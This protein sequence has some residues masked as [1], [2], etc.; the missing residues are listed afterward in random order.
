ME[1][2]HPLVRVYLDELETVQ[3]NKLEPGSVKKTVDNIVMHCSVQINILFAFMLKYGELPLSQSEHSM[4]QLQKLLGDPFPLTCAEMRGVL[5]DICS[6]RCEEV[7][8]FVMNKIMKKVNTELS[9]N[10]GSCGGSALLL[11]RR[12]AFKQN[13]IICMMVKGFQEI[14]GHTP[15]DENPNLEAELHEAS[16]YKIVID[17]IKKILEDLTDDF[18]VI[19]DN[20]DVMEAHEKL[21][22]VILGDTDKTAF[23][24][25]KLIKREAQYLWKRVGSKTTAFFFRRFAKVS[26]LSLVAKLKRK[27]QIKLKTEE[28]SSA[29]KILDWVNWLVEDTLPSQM[30]LDIKGPSKRWV[31]NRIARNLKMQPEIT[32]EELCDLIGIHLNLDEEFQFEN[33]DKIYGEVAAFMMDMMDWL[34]QQ[35]DLHVRERDVTSVALKRIERVLRSVPSFTEGLSVE[36]RSY[37]IPFS[38]EALQDRYEAVAPPDSFMDNECHLV[39]ANLVKSILN[40]PTSIMNDS[41]VNTIILEVKKKLL[42]ELKDSKFSF[43]LNNDST[44]RLIKTVKKDLSTQVGRSEWVPLALLSKEPEFL[45]YTAVTLRKHLVKPRKTTNVTVSFTGAFKS[46]PIHIKFY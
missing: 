4:R 44:N 5:E 34:H 32:S 42:A 33:I 38:E 21:L 11:S 15:M 41:I 18:S 22:P 6:W 7:A 16:P 39:V 46:F 12:S 25:V 40:A 8:T 26:V 37:S 43:D 29:I 2:F 31:Y 20:E 23:E 17:R 30:Y 3:W 45:Q 9:R 13:T 28:N 1:A 19:A 14:L 10:R 35:V 24:I 27:F 36:Q